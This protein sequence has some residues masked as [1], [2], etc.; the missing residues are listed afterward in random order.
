VAIGIGSL[1]IGLNRLKELPVEGQSKVISFSNK[2]KEVGQF[3]CKMRFLSQS[4]KPN[5]KSS[6]VEASKVNEQFNPLISRVLY[7]EQ[8]AKDQI[9]LESSILQL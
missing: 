2:K 5:L 1:S 9:K 6:K 4:S 8:A 3:E 7:N